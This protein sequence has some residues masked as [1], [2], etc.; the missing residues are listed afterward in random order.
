MYHFFQP[1]K[2]S[3]EKHNFRLIVTS[4]YSR[5][6]KSVVGQGKRKDTAHGATGKEVLDRCSLTRPGGVIT[7]WQGNFEFY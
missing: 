1:L 6:T 5:V 4:W 7:T 2:T 3:F